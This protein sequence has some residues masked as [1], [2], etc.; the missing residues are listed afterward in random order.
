MVIKMAAQNGNDRLF[1]SPG[2][3]AFASKHPQGGIQ[4]DANVMLSGFDSL[5]L[6]SLTTEALL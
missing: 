4:D 2:L 3:D 6:R 5:G 1:L